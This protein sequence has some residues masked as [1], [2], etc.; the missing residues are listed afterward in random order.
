MNELS[1]MAA[2]AGWM[3]MGLTNAPWDENRTF[4]EVHGVTYDMFTCDQTELKI[5]IRSNPGIVWLN[6]G[7]VQHKWEWR[8]VPAWEELKGG[9]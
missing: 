1:K 6:N 4:Q 3:S 8:D 2:E 7:V 5:V 9:N